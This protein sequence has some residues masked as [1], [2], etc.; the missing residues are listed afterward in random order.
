M[1][2]LKRLL[3][4]LIWPLRRFFDPRFANIHQHLD[5][6]FDRESDQLVEILRRIEA[7][8]THLDQ[9]LEKLAAGVATDVQTSA[10]LLVS[11]GRSLRLLEDR[12]DQLE[13]SMD[14][15][16]DGTRTDRESAAGAGREN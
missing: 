10:E 5:R 12:F 6:R 2:F 14:T 1:S 11:V 3:R 16:P 4:A 9:R 7:E 13:S 8:L 15:S